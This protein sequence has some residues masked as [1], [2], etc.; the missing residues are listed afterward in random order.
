VIQYDYVTI[1]KRSK[2]VNITL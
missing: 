1:Y 2:L